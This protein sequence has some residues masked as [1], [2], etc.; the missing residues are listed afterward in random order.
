MDDLLEA[1]GFVVAQDRLW[2]MDMARDSLAGELA[3]LLARRR[4]RAR[5]TP[6][7]PADPPRAEHLTATMPRPKAPF[8][9]LPGRQR[10]H[11][12]PTRTAPAE[13][14]AARLQPRPLAA[15]RLRGWSP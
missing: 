9:A 5:Q 12:H 13:F 10:F 4:G 15:G 3:E 1:Q 11:R 8:E 2:Q 14:P 6:A 7:N